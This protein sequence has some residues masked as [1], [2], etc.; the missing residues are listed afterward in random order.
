MEYDGEAHFRLV[1]IL[2][3]CIYITEG[4][5]YTAYEAKGITVFDKPSFDARSVIPAHTTSS[6]DAARS[7]LRPFSEGMSACSLTVCSP[8]PVGPKEQTVGMPIR[9]R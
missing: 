6:M 8:V 9:T 2:E 7:L 4:N 3:A 1:G 5:R